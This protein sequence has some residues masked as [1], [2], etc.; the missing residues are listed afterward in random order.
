MPL[1][2]NEAQEQALRR[3]YDRGALWRRR[4]DGH[5]TTSDPLQGE[6]PPLTYDE[7]RALA[8]V[9]LDVLT[10]PWCGMWLAIERDGY[11]HS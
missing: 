6:G 1:Q 8:H 9:S 10:V 7:F 11:T 3:V 4:E 2:I 5:M